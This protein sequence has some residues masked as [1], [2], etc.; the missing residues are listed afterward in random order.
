MAGAYSIEV[1]AEGGFVHAYAFDA[2]GK[3]HAAGNLD[4]D[5]DV[6]GASRLDLRW[7]PPSASYQAELAAGLDLQAKPIIVRIAADGKA[8]FAAV[9]SFHSSAKL[10]AGGDAK[11]RADVHAHAPS[12]SAKADARAHAGGSTKAGAKIDVHEHAEA[13]GKAGGDAGAKIGGEIKG[14]V[15]IGGGAKGGVKIGG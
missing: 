15:K 12:G 11:L 2:S 6:D 1:V 4:I 8:A 7:D 5:I 14:G 10:A 9:A 3:A 13:S